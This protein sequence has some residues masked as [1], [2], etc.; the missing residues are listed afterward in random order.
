MKEIYMK[1]NNHENQKDQIYIPLTQGK[2]AIVSVQDKYIMQYKWYFNAREKYAEHKKIREGK[3][4]KI[5]MHREI[6]E[7]MLGRTLKKDEFIEHI[8]GD[9]LDNRREN[10]LYPL[11]RAERSQRIASRRIPSGYIGVSYQEKRK[12]WRAQITIN[13]RKKTIGY[14]SNPEEAARA[15][16]DAAKEYYKDKALLNKLPHT[17]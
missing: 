4:K 16:N 5:P 13:S 15:Y 3:I 6:V 11:T 14:Y 1:N 7:V 10:L 2:S 17:E 12:K 9:K 8:N